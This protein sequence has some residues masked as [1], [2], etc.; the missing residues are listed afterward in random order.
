MNKKEVIKHSSVIQ[1]SNKIN[2]LE[3]RSWNVLLANAFDDL[4]EKDIFEISIKKLAEILEYDSNNMEYLK[5]ILRRLNITQI[6]WNILNKDKKMEWGVS[7]LLADARIINGKCLYSYSPFM[8]E[9]LHNPEM[10]ARINLGLQNKFRSKHSLALYELFI[11]YY[12]EKKKYGETPQISLEDLRKLLGLVSG[13][14]EQFKFLKRDVIKKAIDDINKKSDIL[15]NCKYVKSGRKVVFIKFII[16]NNNTNKV[17][18]KILKVIKKEQ[19][20]LPLDKFELDNQELFLTLTEEFGISK[21]KTISIL[22][23]TDEF[24]IKENFDIVRDMIKKGKIE[25]IA[26]YAIKALEEDFRSAK[27]KADIE[28]EK[29]RKQRLEA[30][31]KYLKMKEI[32]EKIYNEFIENILNLEIELLKNKMLKNEIEKFNIWIERNPFYRKNKKKEVII[33]NAYRVYFKKQ[34]LIDDSDERFITYANQKG[35]E[36][37]KEDNSLDI[38]LGMKN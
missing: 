4:K 14:Y 6:E 31:Q 28:K 26:A 20:F 15:I 19:N 7:T 11:D 24:Y 38:W 9:K 2:F 21:K 23:T 3:R 37:K 33:R 29:K 18:F 5:N 30:E 8:R 16:N 34:K 12:D 27:P 10:Y 25:N 32:G 36:V 35:Y 17:D 13:E 1:I 22:Q